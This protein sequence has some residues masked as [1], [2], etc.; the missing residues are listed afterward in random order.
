MDFSMHPYMEDIIGFSRLFI[1][2]RRSI[3]ELILE[4]QYPFYSGRDNFDMLYGRSVMMMLMRDIWLV[5][6]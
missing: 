2:W 6:Y 1:E 3:L 5:W 4:L